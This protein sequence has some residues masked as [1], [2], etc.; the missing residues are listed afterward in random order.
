MCNDRSW[1]IHHLSTLAIWISSGRG[2]KSTL[3]HSLR[4][5]LDEGCNLYEDDFPQVEISAV[6]G[7]RREKSTLCTDCSVARAPD[8]HQ[9]FAQG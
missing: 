5:M 1:I 9:V 8:D 3:G 4:L 7:Y 6:L 2:N